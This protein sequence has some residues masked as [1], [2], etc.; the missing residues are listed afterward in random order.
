MALCFL[1]ATG[2][3]YLECFV[4]FSVEYLEIPDNSLFLRCVHSNMTCIYSIPLLENVAD[5][6][7]TAMDC[8]LEEYEALVNTLE[9]QRDFHMERINAINNSLDKLRGYERT[10]SK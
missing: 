4:F 2:V 1:S 5:L 3:A 8:D 9:E 7:L 10:S 6:C